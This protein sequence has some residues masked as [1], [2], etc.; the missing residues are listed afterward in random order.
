VSARI[1]KSRCKR[2]NV[3]RW[4]MSKREIDD[5]RKVALSL[6]GY[7]WLRTAA[8]SVGGVLTDRGGLAV[9][10]VAR[11][12]HDIPRPGMT[13]RLGSLGWGGYHCLTCTTFSGY[14][15]EDAAMAV[16]ENLVIET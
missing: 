9:G 7:K 12:T 4:T 14:H 2:W 13:V 3:G 16:L 8:P 5:A 11:E 6:A 1:G 15:T 10:W